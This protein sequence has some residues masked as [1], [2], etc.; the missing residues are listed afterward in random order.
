M[1][2]KAL[3]PRKCPGW[4]TLFQHQTDL[5]SIEACQC[6]SNPKRTMKDDSR[7]ATFTCIYKARHDWLILSLLRSTEAILAVEIWLLSLPQKNTCIGSNEVPTVQ[8]CIL[9]TCIRIC[10]YCGAQG[11]SVCLITVSSVYAHIPE[12]M[13]SALVIF[14]ESIC[15]CKEQKTVYSSVISYNSITNRHIV[16]LSR[17]DLDVCNLFFHFFLLCQ[18]FMTL[19]AGELVVS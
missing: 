16:L 13:C 8:L 14:D 17:D 7:D 12:T 11:L 1:K 15:S 6:H 2:Q 3:C 19:S 5:F 10:M 18:F 4:A 9:L